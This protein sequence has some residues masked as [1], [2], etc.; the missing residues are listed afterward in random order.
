MSDTPLTRAMAKVQAFGEE[1]I[2]DAR[3]A[4]AALSMSRSQFDRQGFTAL[5]FG[6]RTKRY[7]YGSLVKQVHD[8]E[9]A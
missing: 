3:E 1:A 6:E 9:A 5:D 7:R 4:A 8:R 2:L